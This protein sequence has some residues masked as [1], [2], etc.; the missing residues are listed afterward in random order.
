MQYDCSDID[1]F[2]RLALCTIV[3]MMAFVLCLGVAVWQSLH[4]RGNKIGDKGMGQLAL[5]LAG[6]YLHRLEVLD[7]G[8]NFISDA[9][10]TE[11]TTE[12]LALV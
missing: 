9:G 10:L 8:F 12:G 3:M 2:V 1:G 6:G 4:L 5:L 7:L 11:V